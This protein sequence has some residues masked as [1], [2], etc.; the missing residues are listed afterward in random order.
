MVKKAEIPGHIVDC[1][2]ALAAERGWRRI[3]L[4]DVARQAKLPLAEVYAHYPSKRA[5][6][7]AFF[8]RIDRE[9]LAGVD[10]ELADEPARDRLFE[11]VMR[12]FDAM[13]PYKATL[14]SILRDLALDPCWAMWAVCR[15]GRTAALLLETADLDSSGLR[16]AIR[17]KGLELVYLSVLRAWFDDDSEDKSRTM[18]ALD[19]RLGRVDDLVSVLRSRRRGAP[20]QADSAAEAT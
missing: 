1:A 18:A 12:R 10:P 2:L 6:L 14:R 17:V 8:D 11:V 20:R 15:L 5:I 16:G 9:T 7:N 4:A 3:A 19:R 13:A